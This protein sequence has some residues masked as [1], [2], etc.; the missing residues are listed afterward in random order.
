MLDLTI[1]E[2]GVYDIPNAA[3]HAQ[4]CDDV[5]YSRSDLW[6]LRE[7]SPRH[8]WDRSPGNPAARE[9]ERTTQLDFG[10]AAHAVLLEG[11]LPEDEFVIQPFGGTYANN[12]HGWKRDEKQAWKQEQHAAGRIIVSNDD[13]EIIKAM[14]DELYEHPMIRDGL[15]QGA[16]ERSV[17]W[18]HDG[19]WLKAR[20]DVQPNDAMLADY[21]SM[22]RADIAF[23]GKAVERYGYHM[24]MAMQIDGLKEAAGHT[25][26]HA[27]IVA[28]EKEPPYV[29]TVYPLDH[30]LLAAGRFEYQQAVKTIKECTEAGFWPGY[31]D[32]TLYLSDW[33]KI[34]LEAE[35]FKS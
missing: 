3:Y 25:I 23:M 8:F 16:V 18:K 24:Q 17:F 11:T 28:Q 7:R 15:F 1:R 20:P 4:I 14:A 35:G 13:L 30:K 32:Q 22:A 21:K 31:P 29:V 19:V 9:H 34:R 12:S 10:A 5:S 2:P 27:A 26:E 33:R 6:P